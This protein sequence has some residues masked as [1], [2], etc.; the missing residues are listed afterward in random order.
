[1]KDYLIAFFVVLAISC[2]LNGGGIPQALPVGIMGVSDTTSGAKRADGQIPEV[3]FTDA[4]ANAT[5]LTKI[6]DS[7]HRESSHSQNG[8]NF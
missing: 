1:M 3:N 7:D 6:D 4:S 8:S 2:F 5:Q